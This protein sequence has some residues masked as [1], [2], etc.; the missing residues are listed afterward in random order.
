[1]A[2]SVFERVH[3]IRKPKDFVPAVQRW[4]VALPNRCDRY[5][6]SF[7][8]IQGKDETAIY[9]SDFFRWM[10]EALSQPA[11]PIVHD[12]ARFVD[13]QGLTNHIVA[14]YWIEPADC[15]AWQRD[16][17]VAGWWNDPARLSEPTGYFRECL[18]VPLDRQETLYWQDY[19][20]ALSKAA[21]V[22]I[23][24]TPW[25]GYYGAMRDRIPLA[26]VDA[27]ETAETS[28]GDPVTRETNGA[29][30]QIHTPHNLAVIRSAAFWGDCDAEQHEDFMTKLRSPLETGMN[31]LR[32]NAGPTGCA[33]LRY[34]QTC[35]TSGQTEAESHA[36][37]YFLSLSHLENWAEGHPSHHAIFS[38][39]IA[40]YRKYGKA[41]QLRTWHEVYVL[42][43]DGQT[44]EYLN[45]SPQTGLLPYFQGERT[46]L[47]R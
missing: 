3:P 1:M 7:Y 35:D 33:S 6:V 31:Y 34:Q 22:S 2:V 25:C 13:Q 47:K 4:S 36:L 40:R 38:A 18:T 45:C 37:G 30:W 8:G 21:E 28:L 46:G 12:H 41:N 42:P 5:F 15:E 10:R 11:A 43:A 29:R 19:P 16:A 27:L 24:P 20:A 17:V 23:Y 9:G 26:A 44:F 32:E 39:A 14:L